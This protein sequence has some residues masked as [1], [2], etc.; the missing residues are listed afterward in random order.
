MGDKKQERRLWQIGE[1]EA[2]V[3]LPD[4]PVVRTPGFT[5][6]GFGSVPGW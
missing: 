1:K 2:V 3:R 6:G 5:A 4:N